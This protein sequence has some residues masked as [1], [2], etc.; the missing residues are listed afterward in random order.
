M[1]STLSKPWHYLAMGAC[2]GLA[3]VMSLLFCAALG[4]RW[5]EPAEPVLGLVCAVAVVG[6]GMVGLIHCLLAAAVRPPDVRE[7][8]V[9]TVQPGPNI[10]TF[11][12]PKGRHLVRIK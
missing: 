11:P 1:K 4:A 7:L 10:E 9:S 3:V 5:I 2:C 12:R 6:V 8:D